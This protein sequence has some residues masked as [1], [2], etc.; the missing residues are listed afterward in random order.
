MFSE[1]ALTQFVDRR[2]EDHDKQSSPNTFT[3]QQPEAESP[4]TDENDSKVMAIIDLEDETLNLTISILPRL[5]SLLFCCV[6]VFIPN[7][8]ALPGA[9]FDYQTK[10]Y[11]FV[12]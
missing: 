6:F 4:H 10:V 5:D 3:G 7:V 8:Y 11:L 9:A 1:L 12:S 2:E